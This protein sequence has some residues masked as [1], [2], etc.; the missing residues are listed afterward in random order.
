MTKRKKI[1]QRILKA[2]ISALVSSLANF[3]FYE[4]I[5]SEEFKEIMLT[6]VEEYNV[7]WDKFHKN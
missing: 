4:D 1:E 6:I 5:S 3:C 7:I 2:Q